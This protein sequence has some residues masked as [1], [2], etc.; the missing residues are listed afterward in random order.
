[1]AAGR[2]VLPPYFPTRDTDGYPVSGAKLYVYQNNTTTLVPVYSGDDLY[3]PIANPVLANASGQFPAIWAEAGTEEDPVLYSIAVTDADGAAPGRPSVFDDY[4]PS[5]DFETATLALVE[6]Y[7]DQVAIDAAESAVNAGLAEDAYQDIVDFASGSP[8]AASIAN[9]ANLTGNNLGAQTQAFVQ[10]LGSF[11]S[12]TVAASSLVA[13]VLTTI[14]LYG[15][16]AA[17]DW[18]DP[19]DYVRNGSNPGNNAGFQTLDGQ[20]WRPSVNELKPEIHGAVGNGSTD[21]STAWQNCVNYA[22]VVR[23]QVRPLSRS[24]AI[25][26]TVSIPAGVVVDGQ[27]RYDTGTVFISTSA[28]GTVFS[29]GGDFVRLTNF[30]LR[31]ATAK[32]GGAYVELNGRSNCYIADFDMYNGFTG[33][34]IK[35]TGASFNHVSNGKFNTFKSATGICIRLDTNGVGNLA[36]FC[37][38]EHNPAGKPLANI[39]IYSCG[40]FTS[41]ECNWLQALKCAYLSAATGK[42]ISSVK[43]LG[44]YLDSSVCALYAEGLG[45]NIVRC[46]VTQGWNGGGSIVGGGDGVILRNTG[47]G[48]CD[49]FDFVR[50]EFPLVTNGVDFDAGWKNVHVSESSLTQASGSA[51]VAG[52][53][54]TDFSICDSIIGPADGL[55]GNLIGV[56][57]GTG[58]NRYKVNDNTIIGN[59]T[60][61]VNGSPNATIRSVLGNI[62]IRDELRLGSG[63]AGETYTK[64]RRAADGFLTTTPEQN[65]NN[66]YDREIRF[67]GTTYTGDRVSEPAAN[68]TAHW[69]LLNLAGVYTLKRITVGAA[70]SGGA[71][72][73]MLRVTN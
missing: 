35:G 65:G 26:T 29:A 43:F 40:D 27:G 33:V 36:T 8:E 58:C 44:G 34:D 54:A 30:Q 48:V 60:E 10:A 61:F 21:D 22:S 63:V 72:F 13:A 45:G 20:W 64:A 18:G 67:G 41:V 46:S 69:A 50:C 62:G 53:G 71:G 38:S 3:T 68:E 28:S 52:N 5:V 1:M 6:S 12:R 7:A 9:K 24:Y 19:V 70:D 49:G 42:N 39:A 2:I 55:L 15:Y 31:S 51:F 37:N 57:I 23:K 17:G 73:R 16:A 66:G 11:P 47:G 14:T 32:T 4:R 25:G 56:N 59:T